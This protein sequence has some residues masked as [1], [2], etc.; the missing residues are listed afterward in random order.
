MDIDRAISRCLSSQAQAIRTVERRN[1]FLTSI[2]LRLMPQE[3]AMRTAMMDDAIDEDMA[4]NELQIDYFS[5]LKARGYHS[6][7]QRIG[8]ESGAPFNVASAS[9]DPVPYP[10]ADLDD[11]SF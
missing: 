11:I 4:A 6:T 1:T 8:Y 3:Y 7:T 10:E 9:E 2:D 5:T